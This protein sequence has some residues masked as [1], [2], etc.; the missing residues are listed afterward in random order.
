MKDSTCQIKVTE[1]YSHL[2]RIKSTDICVHDWF[3]GTHTEG[4]E[5]E[6]ESFL[7]YHP[8]KIVSVD[9][10]EVVTSDGE[11]YGF[12]DLRP[13]I[14]T[15][16]ILDTNLKDISDDS[17]ENIMNITKN[18]T[19]IKYVHQL[20]RLLSLF[21]EKERAENFEIPENSQLIFKND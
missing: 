13:I 18:F 2:D 17:Y 10:N 9:T 19:T 11:I 6:S 15:Q 12:E 3:F 1:D 20:Q 8:V 21:G 7:E 5:D 14:L 16:D 4:G